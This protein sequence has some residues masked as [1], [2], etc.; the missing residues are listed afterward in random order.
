MVDGRFGDRFG[1]DT[2]PGLDVILPDTRFI[3]GQ[4]D[5]GPRAWC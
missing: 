5:A 2:T 1:D 4:R 3:E